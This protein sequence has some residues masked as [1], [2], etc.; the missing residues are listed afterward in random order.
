MAKLTLKIVRWFTARFLKYMFDHSSA[1]YMKGLQPIFPLH[2]HKL[3]HLYLH[4]F[5]W[6]I[7]EIEWQRIKV[8]PLHQYFKLGPVIVPDFHEET[9]TTC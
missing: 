5:C 6:K 1:S 7:N 4:C 3:I 9:K 8:E 2:R